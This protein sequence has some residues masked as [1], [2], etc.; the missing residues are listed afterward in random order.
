MRLGAL[1]A[2]YREMHNISLDRM[3]TETGVPRTVLHRIE[4]G[5]VPSGAH[6]VRLI[7]WITSATEGTQCEI[8]TARGVQLDGRNLCPVCAE[9]V[10]GG[11]A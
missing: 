1:L 7:T 4:H 8:C 9:A 3:V 2:A 11:V 5:Q 6:L 10:S